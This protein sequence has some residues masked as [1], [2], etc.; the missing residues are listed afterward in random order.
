MSCCPSSGFN[1][2]PCSQS[3]K[4]SIG[5]VI[6]SVA[7]PHRGSVKEAGV[8]ISQGQKEASVGGYLTAKHN[9]HSGIRASST[10]TM[11][12]NDAQ[13]GSVVV[14]ARNQIE[15]QTSRPATSLLHGKQPAHMVQ[16]PV[17][18]VLLE[19]VVG[20]KT[21]SEKASGKASKRASMDEPSQKFSCAPKQQVCLPAKELLPEQPIETDNRN[22]EV[23]RMKLR[24]ILGTVPSG[25][26]TLGDSRT[27]ET[28]DNEMMREHILKG[29]GH[30]KS[31][32]DSDTIETDSEYAVMTTKRPVTRS[33]AR[34]RAPAKMRPRN[35][36]PKSLSSDKEKHPSSDIFSF[37]E[38][39]APSKPFAVTLGFSTVEKNDRT[40][41]SCEIEAGDMLSPITDL[42]NVQT[43]IFGCEKE[44]SI[45]DS[46]NVGGALFSKHGCLDDNLEPE[47]AMKDINCNQ[48]PVAREKS[49]VPDAES[50]ATQKKSQFF[51][52]FGG[53]SPV[54]HVD[55]LSCPWYEMTNTVLN[56][57]LHTYPLTY[58]K[59]QNVHGSAQAEAGIL[60][61]D[62]CF[63][64]S[65]T[66]SEKDNFESSDDAAKSE[67]RN[68]SIRE[69]STEEKDV[70]NGLFTQMR[71][72]LDSTEEVSSSKKVYPEVDDV[73]ASPENGSRVAQRPVLGRS[74]RHCSRDVDFGDYS[75]TLHTPKE[76]G[77]AGDVFTKCLD[78][79]PEDGLA[80]VV[81][82]L[83]LALEKVK[84]KMISLTNKKCSEI[85]VSSAKEI[86]S[87]LLN[88]ESQIQTDLVKL[89]SLKTSKRKYLETRLQEQQEHL[90]VIHEKFKK[91]IC[92]YLQD[93][94][95]TMEG[96]ETQ[97][98]ELRGVIERQKTLHR[99]LLLQTEAAVET[100][101]IDAQRQMML[102]RKMGKQKM[103]QLKATIDGCL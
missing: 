64:K 68:S 76:S 12:K 62:R 79:S 15:N 4:M 99:K 5:I 45:V 49:Q 38:K 89:T 51:E 75:R 102:V 90:K 81:S 72:E 83:G 47:A 80:R 87:Q 3:Q 27:C 21:E 2:Q 32:E 1:H 101:L 22:K 57:P 43:E 46:P 36:K 17:N 54:P 31:R 70:G 94:Q 65:S 100:H 7:K 8:S 93:C 50:P 71:G 58:D 59:K 85:M 39:S 67:D 84:T 13:E 55:D 40:K 103:Q 44:P 92:Q 97:H 34:R 26:N 56:S 42:R 96:L 82:L 9:V 73:P 48:S 95:G 33:L 41:K 19:P 53:Q 10:A 88:V 20:N 18:Q 35:F 69:S 14:T 25:N 74:K 98:L 86:H 37:A 6:E 66:A 91:E 60:F 63:F 29:D 11:C 52:H 16:S 30:S 24:E 78:E 23:L 28:N 61:E 77:N